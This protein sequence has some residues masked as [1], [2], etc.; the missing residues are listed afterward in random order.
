[1]TMQKS[2]RQVNVAR[3]SRVTNTSNCVLGRPQTIVSNLIIHLLTKYSPF[4]DLLH[5]YGFV[6]IC[7][8][9]YQWLFFFSIQ[10]A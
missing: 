3:V 10:E 4:M 2:I 5:H 8:M 9:S 7:H 1:M 6:I